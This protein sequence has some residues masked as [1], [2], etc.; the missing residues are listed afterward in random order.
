MGFRELPLFYCAIMGDI[1]ADAAPPN[2]P[3]DKAISINEWDM[4]TPEQQRELHLAR[5]QIV[6]PEPIP[7]IGW[8]RRLTTA[9]ITFVQRLL[10]AVFLAQV[11]KIKW[12]ILW[13]WKN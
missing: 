2:C 8:F 12:S 9:P 11:T 10:M 4:K 1:V 13:K 7:R 3:T 6:I 5:H